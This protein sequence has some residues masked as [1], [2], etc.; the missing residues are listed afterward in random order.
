MMKKTIIS[1]CA[2]LTATAFTACSNEVDMFQPIGTGSATID[3]NVS[4]NDEISVGTRAVTTVADLASW[5]A[6]V[7]KTGETSEAMKA[8][9]VGSKTYKA[10]DK[11][12]V[13]VSNYADLAAAMPASE[14]G[15]A[16]Y[17]GTSEE[18]TLSKG[19]NEMAI[20]CGTAK[21]CRVKA[22]W[23]ETDD[24]KIT[25][26]STSQSGDNTSRSYTF[27]E[28]GKTAYY[29]AGAEIS[30]TVNYTFKSEEKTVTKTISSPAAATEYG[31]NVVSNENGSITL[32]VTY[33][34]E[35]TSG[36]TTTTTID[37]VTGAEVTE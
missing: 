18:K 34:D 22:T 28:N 27:S 6:V 31:L 9:E 30:Y 25:S 17:E 29:Y 24:L 32:S 20:A 5:T 12:T 4:N 3:L 33:N 36:G 37:A 15:A 35:F 8:S 1:M 19:A 10:N 11:V 26:I 23:T 16:Y 7:T 13:K 2:V 14:A 21:N